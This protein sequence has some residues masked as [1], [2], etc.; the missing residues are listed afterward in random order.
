[1]PDAVCSDRVRLFDKTP[2][3]PFIEPRRLLRTFRT[4]LQ[5]DNR[6]QEKSAE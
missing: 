3:E 2:A 1:L 6:F 4:S 5:Y